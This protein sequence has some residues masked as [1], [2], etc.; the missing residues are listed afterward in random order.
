M[1]ALDRPTVILTGVLGLTVL[2]GFIVLTAIGVD[3]TAYVVFLSGPL[4]TMVVGAVLSHKVTGIQATATAVE[5]Q[6][7]GI[8]TAQRDSL[9]DHL[10][11]QDVTAA[12]TAAAATEQQQSRT[13]DPPG[14]P[15]SYRNKVT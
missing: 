10:T 9:Q 2:S 13:Q 1:A 14:W 6:T 5:K 3:T 7:N 11:A 8:A 4:A 12:A 15:E